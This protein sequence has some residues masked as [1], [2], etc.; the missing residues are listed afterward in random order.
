MLSEL[1]KQRLPRLFAMY[2]ADNNGFIESADFDQFLKSYSQFRSWAPGSPQY[3]S[4]QSKLT[5]RW[6][7]MQKFADTN[8]DNKISLDE[9]LVYMD[10]ILNDPEAYEAQLHGIAALA[11]SVFDV[12]GNEQL[13]LEEYK[14]YFRVHN[15]DEN[16][17]KEV[18]KRLNLN[19]DDYISKEKHMELIDQF[20]RS[21]D[22]ESPGN[23]LFIKAI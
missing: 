1:Q 10:N 3:D 6:N 19:D 9:W 4:I 18:F 5:S 7:T 2:D 17:A 21:D 8:G 23:L 12:D 13:D 16:S 14:Q 22:S 11:F 20:F 15:L